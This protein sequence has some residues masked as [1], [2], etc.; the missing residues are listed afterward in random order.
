MFD[1][2]TLDLFTEEARLVIFFARF[3]ASRFG[4]PAIQPEHLLLGLIR[5]DK[6]RPSSVLAQPHFQ[7]IQK[8]IEDHMEL[9]PSIPTSVDMPLDQASQRI[10]T[11]AAEEALISGSS[12]VVLEHLLLAVGR[13]ESSFAASVL[14]DRGFNFAD[15]RAKLQ[16]R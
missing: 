4:C 15:L 9:G 16:A 5:Q 3:E 7:S 6:E 13:E 14:K 11:H 2:H 10:L 1:H 8:Q 12:E